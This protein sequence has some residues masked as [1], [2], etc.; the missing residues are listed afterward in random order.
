RIVANRAKILVVEDSRAQL[1]RVVEVL[2]RE[3]YEV[4]TAS[5]GRE[6]VKKA[7]A[8]S[9]DLVLLDMV[10]P[11]MDGLEVLRILKAARGDQFLPVIL[12]SVKSDLDSRVT[13]LRIGADDFLAKPFADA[14]V[15]ARAAAMLRIKQLQ[16]QLRE[17][18]KTMEKLS[19]EDGLTKLYN[20]RHFQEELRREFGRAQRYNDP[21]SLIMID[22]D[23]FKDVND[24]YGHPFGDKV[25]RE[26]AALVKGS[27]RDHDLCA[28][29]GGEEIAVILPKTMMTGA[30]SV[31]ERMH[32]G[33]NQKVFEEERPQPRA[34]EVPPGAAVKVT[35]SFGVASYPSKDITSAE[36]LV[37]YAD[38][39]LYRAKRE[40][41][42]AIC[43]Y[44]S[45]S[46][47]YDVGAGR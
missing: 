47:R 5:E 20:H 10:L 27:V 2:A 23:H 42:N 14:E 25:L 41:R 45:Q 1:E 35:A 3:G 44:Q 34:G 19:I 28:R 36:L 13:G 9:P 39:A 46:Y 8:D 4:L 29:Y 37:R 26:T 17:A 38:E 31:A 32:R 6:G 12:L 24:R 15:L 7:A 16:D 21:L 30:L 22:L 40:G 33:M 43:V 11:D 18:K